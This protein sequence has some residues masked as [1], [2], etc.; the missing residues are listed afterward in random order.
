MELFEKDNLVELKHLMSICGSAFAADIE[1]LDAAG[2]NSFVTKAIELNLKIQGGLRI[3]NQVARSAIAE[4]LPFARDFY[5]TAKRFD[6]AEGPLCLRDA[7]ID[8]NVPFV[9]LLRR[10]V[11]ILLV[12][13][14]GEGA[15]GSEEL[16]TAEKRGYVQI[17]PE[18]AD[19]LKKPFENENLRVFWPPDDSNQ[20]VIVY[21]LG[22]TSTETSNFEYS[23]KKIN[24]VV[25]GVAR[26]VRESREEILATIEWAIERLQGQKRASMSGM[27]SSSPPPILEN[28]QTLRRALQYH[29][30]LRY[31]NMTLMSDEKKDF[32]VMYTDLQLMKRDEEVGF[33]P[34]GDYDVSTI[35]DAAEEQKLTRVSIQGDAGFGKSTFC[36]NVARRQATL[37]ADRFEGIVMIELPDLRGI[38]GIYDV[39]SILEAGSVPP[40]T[41][42]EIAAN[43][44]KV[45]WVWDGYV[46][47]VSAYFE[48]SSF[49]F[50]S[51]PP[52]LPLLFLSPLLPLPSS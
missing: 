33:I 34:S 23:P 44:E 2:V 1:C 6:G 27:T 14:A 32:G 12:L 50:R 40:D 29:Y 38:A 5:W 9:P 16:A 4:L 36:K 22:H 15:E 41:H 24:A 45:L 39:K 47:S 20:P 35:W 3:R 43:P 10:G 49:R 31:K 52:T 25:T 18:Q 19:L 42:D 8:V 7:G 46:L 13:D 11:D 26:K 48:F 51:C 21:M 37:W 17:R 30:T 28:S